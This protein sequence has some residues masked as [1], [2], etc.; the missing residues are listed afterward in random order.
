MQGFTEKLVFPGDTYPTYLYIEM[1]ICKMIEVSNSYIK[2]NI[3]NMNQNLQISMMNTKQIR[4]NLYK[5][6]N[7]KDNPNIQILH[8]NVN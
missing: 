3:S 4:Q 5:H 1:Q 8:Q 7:L 6:V 2:M